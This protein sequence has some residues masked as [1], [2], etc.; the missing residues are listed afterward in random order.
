MYKLLFKQFL[1]TRLCQLGLILMLILGIISIMIGR[2]FLNS[3]E[4]MVAQVEK[5][6]LDHIRR[7]ADLHKDD[8][9]LLLY[10]LKFSLVNEVS[11]LAALSIGQKDITPGVES[12][13]ILTLEGQKY[14]AD[15]INPVKLLY[16]N[17]DLSF[18]LVY[19][20]PLLV[21]AFTYNLRSEEVETGTWKLVSVTC[22]SGF[23]FLLDKLVV[24]AILIFA[25]MALLFVL[26]WI[27]LDIPL[28]VLF[29][30]F[31]V[32]GLLYLTFWLVLGFWIISLKRD[33]SFNALTLFSIWLI[34]VVL[35]PAALNNFII[36]KYPISE[37]FTTMIKQRD[38]YHKKWDTNKRASIEKFY[39]HY[40]RFKHF[41]YPPEEGF[42]WLW[43]YAMQ[44]L[45]DEESRAESEAMNKKIELREQLSRKWAPFVPSMH[46]QLAFNDMA[47]T[48]L[49]HY[50][51][52]LQHT[53]LFHEEICLYF[54]PKIFANE[55]ADQVDWERFKPEYVQLKPKL[56]WYSL[57]LPQILAIVILAGL[58]L[59][60]QGLG[61]NR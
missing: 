20:L 43:Y 1:R 18:L 19:I 48:S 26:A 28:N 23:C 24:R 35:L 54:Y 61:R 56:S 15:L 3:Q 49:S 53:N 16:G 57:F 50:M 14:E 41:G 60:N 21:I 17:L 11:P 34:Q 55:T 39:E 44:Y 8:I 52:F 7:N 30:E 9:G 32:L 5:K 10:Y 40:P 29:L 36:D 13:N 42:N 31:M 25:V 38:G 58:I 47:G 59:I 2:Q 6:Q 37:A 4:K 27:V 45:G 46:A 12:V 22:K 51:D 33:S